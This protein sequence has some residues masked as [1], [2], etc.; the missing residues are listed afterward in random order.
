VNAIRFLGQA[1]IERHPILEQW[2]LNAPSPS[3]VNVDSLQISA[4]EY[5]PL[6]NIRL[7]SAYPVLEGYKDVPALGWR[8]NFSDAILLHNM[9]V[10]LSYSPD[11]SLPAD[12]R[13]HFSFNHRFWEWTLR[14]NYDGG[15][16]YDMFGPTKATRKGYS[17][18]VQYKKYIVYDDPKTFDYTL[19]VAGYGGLERLPEFQNVKILFVDRFATFRGA[20]TYQFFN[21]SIGAVDDEKGIRWQLISRNTFVSGSIVPRLSA[22]V[23]YG[24]ALPLDHSSIWVRG[25]AGVSSGNRSDPFANFYF[26]A[27][28]NNWIDYQDAKRFREDY[29]F[30]GVE[31]NAI[32]GTNYGRAQL[33]WLLPPA[34]F[35][36]FGS[37]GLY[38][39]WARMSFFASL[40]SA[41]VDDQLRRTTAADFGAQLD[42]RISFLSSFEST[43]SFG[44]A[45]AAEESQR[46]TNEFMVSLKLLK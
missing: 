17:G 33:E 11:Q 9:D 42:F 23:D 36:N 31:L 10:T 32:G 44:T 7:A 14:A 24:I 4:G 26:G 46:L 20:L 28:G 12:E 18:S 3:A 37:P 27:F 13:L 21:R 8:F 34:R 30:P 45:L 25:A 41:N 35:S 39:N 19:T 40:L 5:E 1:I 2:K 22:N 15:N 29:S 43:L 16:F 38:C 6:W